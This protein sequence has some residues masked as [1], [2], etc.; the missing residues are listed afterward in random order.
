M[1][2]RH[3]ILT[4]LSITYQTV[5]AQGQYGQTLQTQT[6]YP[7]ETMQF[8]RSGQGGQPFRAMSMPPYFYPIPPSTAYVPEGFYLLKKKKEKTKGQL[9]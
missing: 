7:L 9:C 4:I 3:I 6:I 1:K 8:F 5:F 2:R